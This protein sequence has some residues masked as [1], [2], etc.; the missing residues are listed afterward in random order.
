M[1][2]R[3]AAPNTLKTMISIML[4]WKIQVETKMRVKVRRDVVVA[5]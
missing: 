1:N 2:V 4:T 5:E 3:Y